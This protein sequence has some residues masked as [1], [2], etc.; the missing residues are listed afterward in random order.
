MTYITRLAFLFMLI[1]AK[2]PLA[3][4]RANIDIIKQVILAQTGVLV[5]KDKINEDK[6]LSELGLDAF[7]C[8]EIIMGLEERLRITI[9]DSIIEGIIG[10]YEEPEPGL[11]P[12]ERNSFAE[13]LT[14]TK[15]AKILELAIKQ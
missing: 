9:P 4:E 5:L 7:D 11:G 8:Y 2:S 10:P 12:T 13:K 6:P 15:L 1:L 14:V 3:L